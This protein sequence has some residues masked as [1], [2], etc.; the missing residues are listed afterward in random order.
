MIEMDSRTY[1]AHMHT[2]LKIPM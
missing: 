2:K 1:S